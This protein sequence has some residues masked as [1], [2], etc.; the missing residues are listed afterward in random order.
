MGLLGGARVLGIALSGH[1]LQ[2]AEL[3]GAAGRFTLARTAVFP[4][5]DRLQKEP[6]ALGRELH[7]FL[8]A[9][10]FAAR[11]AIAGFP[12]QWMMFKEK[13]L[14]AAS[15]DATAGMLSLQ[16][17]R[18][19]S[20]EP[21]SL[22][23]DFI[24]G[25]AHKGTQRIIL[26]AT[27]RERIEQVRQLTL[28]AG[29]QLLGVTSTALAIANASGGSNVLYIGENGVECVAYDEQG[30]RAIR[31]L[32]SAAAVKS[33]TPAACSELRRAMVLSGGQLVSGDLTIWDDLGVAGAIA[34]DLFA[35]EDVN[36]QRGEKFDKLDASSADARRASAGIALALCAANPQLAG[37]DFLHSRLAPKI[38][39]RFTSARIW[40]A[41]AGVAVLAGLSYLYLDW[42]QSSADLAELKQKRD[43][44]KGNVT[45][46]KEFVAR[47]KLANGWGDSRPN[48]L[49]CLR[50]LTLCFPE[51]GRVWASTL[52]IRD[53]MKGILS[54]GA[55]DEKIVLD[56]IDKLKVNPAFTDLKLLQ[57]RES[58]GKNSEVSFTIAFSYLGG[59]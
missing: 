18:D 15:A 14:P 39:T 51:E 32:V 28:A 37:I 53:D 56:L 13:S 57:M 4:L 7:Q 6:V 11:Q 48:Y 58:E 22:A 2:L 27:V 40:A 20:M 21:S 24:P 52:S 8:K 19:F 34:E 50:T 41:V 46:A 47:V 3:R 33:T 38:P 5:G 1:A 31:Y 36:I 55:S 44:M 10:G 45:S 12:A 30:V 59:G 29:L 9:N 23:L 49:E 17:E 54:G 35:E 25:V 26:A 43:E 16:A 42:R